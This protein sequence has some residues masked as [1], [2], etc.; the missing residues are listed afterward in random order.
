MI[1]DLWLGNFLLIL[2]RVLGFIVEAPALGEKNLPNLIKVAMVFSLSLMLSS[3]VTPFD[4][5]TPG[6][7]YPFALVLNLAVGLFLGFLS[8]LGLCVIEALGEILDFQLGINFASIVNPSTGPTTLMNL[9]FRNYA[10]VLFLQAGCLEI[11]LI[12]LKKSFGTFPLNGTDFGALGITFP[13][14]IKLFGDILGLGV[15]LS[16]PFLI[17]LVFVDFVLA[18]MQRS[19]QQVNAFELSRSA[20]PIIGIFILLFL[21]PFLQGRIVQVLLGQL[22]FFK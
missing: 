13:E 7:N 12:G 1:F 20:K 6:F 16:A 5:N 21:L 4:P 18:L 14:I 22:Y 17:I 15:V 2:A 19:A 10:L 8:K 9:L 3:V 11:C